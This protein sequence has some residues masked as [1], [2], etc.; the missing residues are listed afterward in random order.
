MDPAFAE[1]I[2]KYGD[3]KNFVIFVGDTSA[4]ALNMLQTKVYAQPQTTFF[5]LIYFLYYTI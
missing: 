3:D 1:M 2:K 5:L 4:P